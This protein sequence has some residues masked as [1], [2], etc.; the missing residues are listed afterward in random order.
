MVANKGKDGNLD[1]KSDSPRHKK[2][3]IGSS[4]PIF[5]RCELIRERETES[6]SDQK[7]IVRDQKMQCQR[8]GWKRREP[9]SRPQLPAWGDLNHTSPRPHQRAVDLECRWSRHP[10]VCFFFNK[11]PRWFWYMVKVENTRSRAKW[12]W[13]A[14]VQTW[15]WSLC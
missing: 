6:H 1:E 2:W 10:W 12:G 11:Y 7:G 14:S 4:R 3:E 8:D 13:R 5:W 9:F 15:P